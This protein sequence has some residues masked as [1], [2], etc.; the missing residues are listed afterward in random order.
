MMLK[1][2]HISYEE[3]KR[4]ASP[5][6]KELEKEAEVVAREFGEKPPKFNFT[7]LMR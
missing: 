5:L 1:L 7:N 2:G 3:A 6:I 4:Q